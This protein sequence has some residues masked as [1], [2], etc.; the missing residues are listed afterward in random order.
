MA[1]VDVLDELRERIWVRYALQLE[2]AYREQY[3]PQPSATPSPHVPTDAP[4]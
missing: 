1:V 3:A 4:C 2:T